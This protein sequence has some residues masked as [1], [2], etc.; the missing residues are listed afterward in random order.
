M[1]FI[2]AALFVFL[3]RDRDGPRTKFRRKNSKAVEG[4]I[5]KAMEQSAYCADHPEEAKCVARAK[6]KK[7]RRKEQLKEHI[8]DYKEAMK[9]PETRAIVEKEIQKD[10]ARK[11]KM[12]KD[13][14]KPAERRELL[15][16]ID[17]FCKDPNT[18]SCKM[19]KKIMTSGR[20]RISK[21]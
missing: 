7:E 18:E 6:A 10:E 4:R 9:D 17:K 2:V 12:M 16:N 14:M 20:L 5:D 1:K 3:R 19:A 8:Q 15:S 21:T 11:E 13:S